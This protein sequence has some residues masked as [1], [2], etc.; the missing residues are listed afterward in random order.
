MIG[1]SAPGLTIYGKLRIG[2][3]CGNRIEAEIRYASLLAAGISCIGRMKNYVPV[4][5][6]AGS[7]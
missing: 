3:R 7:G 1:G 6:E 4:I 5:F 2:R